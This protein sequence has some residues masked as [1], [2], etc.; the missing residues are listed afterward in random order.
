MADYCL[1]PE[2]ANAFL[3]KLKDGTLTPGKLMD[4]SSAE[5]RKAFGDIIGEDHAE[6]VNAL[7]E[8]KMLL[9]D[10]QRGMVTW[11]KQVAGISEA[12]RNDILSRIDKL[13]RVLNPKEER[14]FLADLAAR[15]LGVTVTAD[16]AKEIF[17]LSQ[18]AKT[19]KATMLSDMSN[20]DNRIA[21]GRAIMDMQ[22]KI[23]SLKQSGRTWTELAIDAA[24]APKTLLTGFLHF[25]APFVQNWGMLTINRSWEA[26]GQ[27]FRYF[28][29]EENYKNL[30][31]YI[32]SHP[33]YQ[34]AVDGKLGI[35]KLGDKLSAREEAIQSSLVEQ[36]NKYLSEKTGV[37]NVIRASS[38]AFTGYLNYVR[39]NRFTDLLQAAR[40]NGEDVKVGSSI[41]RDLAKVVNDFTGRGAIGT[42]D[43]YASAVP[44]LNAAFFAPRKLSATINMFNPKRYL[45]P[46]V[47]PIARQAAIRQL[48]GSLIATGA[49]LGIARAM[50]ARVDS[51]PRSADFAKVNIKGEKLDMTG[52]NA[53]YARLL[54]RVATGQEITS[55]EKLIELGQGFRAT[56]RADLVLS[57]LRGKLAPAAAFMADALYGKDQIGRPFSV[58]NEAQEHLIPI[59]VKN[60]LDYA[61]N[62]PNDTV[63]FLP[64]LSSMFGV[65]LESPLPPLPGRERDI[66]GE[67]LNP[68]AD[69]S[70][71]PLNRTLAHI[72]YSPGYAPK[73]IRGV[74]L[75]PEQYDVYQQYSGRLMRRAIGNVTSTNG[76]DRLPIGMQEQIVR[77]AAT[78]AR[79]MATDRVLM[80]YPKIIRQAV[81]V[82]RDN[83]RLGSESARANRAAQQ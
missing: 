45:D 31:A 26:F 66:W 68:M 33:D 19:A 12:R 60:F 30:N 3:G 42:G 46:S 69:A 36:A 28:A 5:R 64:A 83:L 82:K 59:V 70:S 77:K 41:V 23:E 79:D 24:N 32:I 61:M 57:Y 48:S 43:K 75:N 15:K 22:E 52:G 50:G 74:T 1:P 62:N 17:G 34:L 78:R 81:Q 14:E 8:G 71:D 16:E 27:M 20:V 40:M 25:S 58:T 51:D 13:D 76:F 53:I 9:K 7:F 49:I 11:A 35:T 54:A 73:K 47:S 21:Y 55:K 10:Q 44:A 67:K 2:L 18:A 37:P 56:T 29:D 4:M 72:G 80:K 38:R 6:N 39:F 63:A 65:E